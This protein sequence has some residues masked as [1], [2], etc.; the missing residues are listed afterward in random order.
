MPFA[1][2]LPADLPFSNE[3]L[4]AAFYAAAINLAAFLAFAWDK[5]CARKGKRRISERTLLLLALLGGSV[6]AVIGQRT[7]RH[8]TFKEPFRSN[9]RLIVV[10]QVAAAVAL[11]FPQVR[12]AL[13]E[14][15]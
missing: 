3:V 12:E 1:D 4:A 2:L 13:W 5:H 8:K 14:L 11:S 9:L 7:L 6:G 10:L 15:W